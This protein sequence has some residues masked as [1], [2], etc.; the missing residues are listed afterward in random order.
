M[1]EHYDIIGLQDTKTDKSD[2]I[3]IDGFKVYLKHRTNCLRKSGGI[4]IA[5]KSRYEQYIT[6]LWM[7]IA[8]IIFY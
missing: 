7:K 4:G 3:E 2:D 8:T 1:L 5:F 6:I